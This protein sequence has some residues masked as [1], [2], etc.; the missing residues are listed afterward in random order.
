MNILCIETSTTVCSVCVTADE[1][2]LSLR[3]INSGFTHAENFKATDKVF[4]STLSIGDAFL[5]LE[6]VVR[7]EYF[8]WKK[9]NIYYRGNP[10]A[11]VNLGEAEARGEG[12]LIKQD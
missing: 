7:F 6:G 9:G 8:I 1:K 4:L 5:N 3:E 2:I 12:K 10:Q 11:I